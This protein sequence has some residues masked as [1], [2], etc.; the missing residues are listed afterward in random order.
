MLTAEKQLTT[1]AGSATIQVD[2]RIKVHFGHVN[3]S[4]PHKVAVCVGAVLLYYVRGGLCLRPVTDY[5][6][7]SS[8][9]QIRFAA[10]PAATDTRKDNKNSTTGTPFRTGIGAVTSVL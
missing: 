5:L 9:L 4:P 3:K 1:N 8:H 2:G 6:C 7:P 10:I